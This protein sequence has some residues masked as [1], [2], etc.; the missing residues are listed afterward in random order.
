LTSFCRLGSD[1]PH[2]HQQHRAE[3]TITAKNS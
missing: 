2:Q 3:V 1:E